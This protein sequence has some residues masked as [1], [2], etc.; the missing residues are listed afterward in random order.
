MRLAL[1]LF[2]FLFATDGTGNGQTATVTFAKDVAPIL[3]KRCVTCHRPGE[4]A[5]MSLITYDEVRPWSA[6]IRE[7]VSARTIPPWH[8]DPKHGHFSNDRRLSDVEIATIRRW[9]ELGAREGNPD[10]LPPCPALPRAGRW[11]LL[12]LYSRSRSSR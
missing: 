4:V 2:A 5:P 9:A 7:A 11:E 10:E 1:C 8:A 12:T 3:Y 6:A